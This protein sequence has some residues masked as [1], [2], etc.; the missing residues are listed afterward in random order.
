[1]RHLSRFL[2]RAAQEGRGRRAERP[3]DIPLRGWRDIL[4]RVFHE[5]SDDHASLIAAGVTFYTLLAVFPLLTALVSLYSLVSDPGDIQ[6]Q[7]G[8]L[9]GVMPGAALDVIGPRLE[10]LSEASKGGVSFAFLGGLALALWSG[11]QGMKAI[12]EALNIA[13]EESENRNIV[14]LNV[15]SLMF[16]VI[17]LAGLMVALVV[18]VAVPPFLSRIAPGAFL[19]HVF[20]WSRWVILIVLMSVT[21]SLL[22]RFGPCRRHPRWV[23]VRTGALTASVLWVAASAAFSFYLTHFSRY[24]VTY[25]TLGAAIGFLMWVW[26]STLLFLLGA[27]L[28][29][30]IEHQTAQDTTTGPRRPPGERGARMADSLGRGHGKDGS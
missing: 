20:L 26:L 23:W 21:A 18:I 3:S 7:L 5:M 12:I 24:D 30:E 13:Y 19:S 11:N 9:N 29:A 17:S 25:G 28:N 6:G 4:F 10:A 22:Y 14:W 16:T 8:A 2:R 15:M 27:E 1:M